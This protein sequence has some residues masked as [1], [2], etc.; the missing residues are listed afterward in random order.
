MK[1]SSQIVVRRGDN[2]GDEWVAEDMY[3]FDYT[4]PIIDT[5]QDVQLLFAQQDDV[6]GETAWGVVVPQASAGI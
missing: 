5:Q 4:K 6:T 2:E 1:G 3:S